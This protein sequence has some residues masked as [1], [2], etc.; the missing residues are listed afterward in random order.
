MFLE[1]RRLPSH[2]SRHNRPPTTCTAPAGPSRS[3]PAPAG[4]YTAGSGLQS[5]SQQLG[6]MQDP[7]HV[8]CHTTY[9]C[10][11]KHSKIWTSGNVERVS[12]GG[13]KQ[14]HD[15]ELSVCG[16]VRSSEW[17]PLLFVSNHAATAYELCLCSPDTDV[18]NNSKCYTERRET[19]HG[20]NR[21]YPPEKCNHKVQLV[22]DQFH[23]S[24][25]LASQSRSLGQTCLPELGSNFIWIIRHHQSVWL[26]Q[27]EV[28][29][30]MII[31]SYETGGE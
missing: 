7:G 27:R 31:I 16:V 24:F 20:N 17:I 8:L 21:G 18:T 30:G 28:I 2:T 13:K 19:K 1:E 11:S 3:K 14:K 6:S 5:A 10:R 15:L 4:P 25:P 12:E 22:R 9:A 26:G 29:I 23:I